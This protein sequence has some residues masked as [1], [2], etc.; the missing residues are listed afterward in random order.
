M[1]GLKTA[2]CVQSSVRR[3]YMKFRILRVYTH[4]VERRAVTGQSK[5]AD[6]SCGNVDSCFISLLQNT[7]HL[8]VTLSTMPYGQQQMWMDGTQNILQ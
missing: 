3:S 2:M 5:L 1:D 8:T 7:P 4:S 6:A